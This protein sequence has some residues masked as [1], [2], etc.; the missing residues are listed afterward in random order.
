MYESIACI[1]IILSQVAQGFKASPATKRADVVAT[2]EGLKE[3][4]NPGPVHIYFGPE[5]RKKKSPPKAII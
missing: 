1:T 2:N 5:E 4:L 3:I